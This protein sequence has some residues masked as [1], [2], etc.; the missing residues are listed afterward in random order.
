MLSLTKQLLALQR[1]KKA[2][3]AVSVLTNYNN[4][5]IAIFM[6]QKG[7]GI[8]VYIKKQHISCPLT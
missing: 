2:R 5:F 6:Y 8:M 1:E 7:F 4:T 3:L